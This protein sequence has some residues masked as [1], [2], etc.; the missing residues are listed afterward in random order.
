MSENNSLK[1]EKQTTGI[2][3]FHFYLMSQEH[4]MAEL[5]TKLKE[6]N[7][8]LLNSLSALGR[9]TFHYNF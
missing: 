4:S 7:E 2:P 9:Y 5:R 3:I 8:K 6:E 1:Q